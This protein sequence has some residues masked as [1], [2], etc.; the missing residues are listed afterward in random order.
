MQ[1]MY[2]EANQLQHNQ[3]QHSYNSLHTAIVP[4]ITP[5]VWCGEPSAS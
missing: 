2:K 3:L 5:H 1:H 4:V